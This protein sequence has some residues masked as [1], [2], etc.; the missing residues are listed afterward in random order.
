MKNKA[1]QQESCLAK[2]QSTIDSKSILIEVRSMF[3]PAACNNTASSGVASA[4]LCKI[5]SCWLACADV[6]QFI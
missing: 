4:N 2:G 5:N 1:L 3:E 6:L